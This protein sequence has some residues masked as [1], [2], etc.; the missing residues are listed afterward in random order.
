MQ[1]TAFVPD[2]P[3][4]NEFLKKTVRES[5]LY[6][7]PP[8]YREPPSYQEPPIQKESHVCWK[9][10]YRCRPS[11][12][13]CPNCGSAITKEESNAGEQSQAPCPFCHALIP[14]SV[15]FCHWCG[16]DLSKIEKS[17]T[18]NPFAAV[19]PAPAVD[20]AEAVVEAVVEKRT[21]SLTI[22]PNE[23]ESLDEATP[24]QFDGDEV[25]LTRDNTEPVNQ[26]ITSKTQAVLTYENDGW[27][28][29]DRSE[30][31]TT[32][33]RAGDRFQIKSGDMIL[34]GNRRFIFNG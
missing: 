14:A 15:K 10:G 12:T 24:L 6:D 11:D 7:D 31:K 2:Q 22:V 27:Y 17:G 3:P 16:A 33:I 20:D 4:A 30:M 5:S 26:T 13:S 29:E 21:C 18:I 25:V 8:S 34:L 9:C 19:A 23:N 28:I 32:F 1:A